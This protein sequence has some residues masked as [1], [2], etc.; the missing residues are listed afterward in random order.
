MCVCVC[1]HKFYELEP[2][3][4]NKVFFVIIF[5]LFRKFFASFRL[6]WGIW[7][8]E[9]SFPVSLFFLVDEV[10]LI[11]QKVKGDCFIIVNFL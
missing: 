3:I 10:V 5:N 1:L 11:R 2:V 6:L 4:N 7:F 8:F 9:F